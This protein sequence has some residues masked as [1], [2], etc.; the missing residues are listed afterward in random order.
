MTA[1]LIVPRESVVIWTVRRSNGFSVYICQHSSTCSGVRAGGR[2]ILF[3]SGQVLRSVR[4]M[5]RNPHRLQRDFMLYQT[6]Y[7]L[8]NIRV[9]S[10]NRLLGNVAVIRRG[11]INNQP[12]ASPCLVW[13]GSLSGT[14][15]GPDGGHAQFGGKAL[16][17]LLYEERRGERLTTEDKVLHLCHHRTASSPATFTWAA[18]RTTQRTG[19]GDFA[20]LPCRTYP[21]ER[22]HWR[23]ISVPRS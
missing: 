3:P 8:R 21:T 2:P 11:L 7:P 15:N 23:K 10:S 13:R 9:S 16:H 14:W 4:V 5:Y 19:R 17:R 6:G 12:N 1:F 18:T 20:S 22:S